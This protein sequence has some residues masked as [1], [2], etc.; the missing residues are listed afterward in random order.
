VDSCQFHS[1]FRILELSAFDAIVG[2]DW[3]QAFSPMQVHWEQKWIAIPYQDDW[4]VLQGLDFV[5]P[6]SVCLQLFAV[7]DTAQSVQP[8]APMHPEIQ[9]LVDSFATLFEPPTTLPPS[10]SCNQTITL[11]PGAQPVFVRPYRYPPNLKDEIEKQVKEMLEEGIIQPSTSSFAS[12]VLLVN[13]KDGSYRFCVDF[14]QLNALIAK[15]KF[16]VPVFDQFMDELAHASWFSKLDL[17]VGFHQILM[18]LEESFKTAFQ[19]HL[20]QYEF[21]VMAFGLTGALGTFQGAMNS[22]LAPGLRHFVLVFFDDI[23]VYSKTFE[24]HVQHLATVFS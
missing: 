16:P 14:R 3:L 10:W 22:T 15:S 1:N 20:G 23:L 8:P 2:M 6:S 21:N 18:Q 17:R 11:L 24:D 4:S 5:Q 9:H 12:P 19:T 7:E 13:K